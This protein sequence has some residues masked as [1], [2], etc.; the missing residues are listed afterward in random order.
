MSDDNWDNILGT[1]GSDLFGCTGYVNGSTTGDVPTLDEMLAMMKKFEEEIE[2]AAM[3]DAGL[4]GSM[5]VVADPG[6]HHTRRVTIRQLRDWMA[7]AF[8]PSFSKDFDG[9]WLAMT[10]KYR[11]ATI[12]A[13]KDPE[14][15]KF[16]S[17]PFSP[18]PTF[19]FTRYASL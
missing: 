13:I 16:P 15:F 11:V 3:K 9:W 4:E 19:P 18:L 14:P 6:V 10:V 1:D 5:L 8:I 2:S 7:G 17:M 12:F